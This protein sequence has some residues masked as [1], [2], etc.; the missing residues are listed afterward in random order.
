MQQRAIVSSELSIAR[1]VRFLMV[2]S[3][4]SGLSARLGTS[5][6]IFL[7]LFRNLIDIFFS[8]RRHARRQQDTYGDFINIKD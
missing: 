6:R 1:L 2:E 7:N 5:A 4:H 3:D 8:G